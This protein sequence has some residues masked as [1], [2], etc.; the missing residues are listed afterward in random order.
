MICNR[1]LKDSGGMWRQV[2]DFKEVT[3]N[4]SADGKL[5]ETDL[6]RNSDGVEQLDS[7]LKYA[8]SEATAINRDEKLLEWKRSDFPQIEAATKD[9][10]PYSALWRIA[11]A[12]TE[13]ERLWMEEPFKGLDA[14]R[15]DT[16]AMEWF[17]KAF[18]LTKVFSNRMPLLR[19][20]EW[21][22]AAADALRKM[23]PLVRAVTNPG[24]RARH[25]TKMGDTVGFAISH[26]VETM[27]TML[28]KGCID[29]CV[30]TRAAEFFCFRVHPNSLL[31]VGGS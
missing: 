17:R 29:K 20:A 8:A 7:R 6:F 4:E 3:C 9:L 2:E 28:D 15:M 16:L 23:V 19:V 26:Q 1:A 31:T 13:N 25:W 21:V 5:E 11:A 14:D 22:R 24:M 12:L 30:V 18:K 10:E 27:Q